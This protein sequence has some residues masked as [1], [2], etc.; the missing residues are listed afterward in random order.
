MV[1]EERAAGQVDRFLRVAAADPALLFVHR[2]DGGVPRAQPQGGVSFPFLGEPDRLGELDVAHLPG[3]HDHPATA[4][5]GGKLLMVAGDQH[6]ALLL[7]S[8]AHDGGQIAHRHHRRL[9]QQQ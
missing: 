2:G 8:K 3:E 4:L 6:P 9:I 7:C 5:D 1:S